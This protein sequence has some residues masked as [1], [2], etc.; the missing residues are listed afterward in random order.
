MV[1]LRARELGAAETAGAEVEI[2]KEQ[3]AGA[4]R[5]KGQADLL[6]SKTAEKI[7]AAEQ[8]LGVISAA[9]EK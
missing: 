1:Q 5:R 9:L 6:V 4:E 8:E 3:L 2:L 7:H